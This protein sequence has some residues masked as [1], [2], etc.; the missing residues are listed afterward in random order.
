VLLP[1]S[2]ATKKVLSSEGLNQAI[3]ETRQ[4]Q[5]EMMLL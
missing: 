4:E 3:D 2:T 1:T 5:D